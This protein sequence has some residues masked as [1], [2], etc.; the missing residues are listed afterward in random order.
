MA[1]CNLLLCLSLANLCL[2]IRSAP[3]ILSLFLLLFGWQCFSFFHLPFFFLSLA[4]FPLA[5]CNLLLPFTFCIWLFYSDTF[6]F[7]LRS[8]PFLSKP[9][10]CF[11]LCAIYSFPFSQQILAFSLS[12]RHLFFP[13]SFAFSFA[14]CHASSFSIHIP[15]LLFPSL[16]DLFLFR[17]PRTIYSFPSFI[18][19]LFY[20]YTIH[21]LLCFSFP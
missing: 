21:V 10:P 13:F 19:L 1:P 16:A 18:I 5:P 15:F 17:R 14:D 20:S 7:P 9:G 3:P 11:W 12:L 2:L 6:P 4:F 8:F